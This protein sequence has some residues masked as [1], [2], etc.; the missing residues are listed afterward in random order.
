MCNVIVSFMETLLYLIMATGLE[1]LL[2]DSESS[3]ILNL[4]LMNPWLNPEHNPIL[5]SFIR[6]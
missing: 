2:A 5:I 6:Y 4:Y 3:T 1:P